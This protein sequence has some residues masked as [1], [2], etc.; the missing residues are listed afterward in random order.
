MK[1]KVLKFGLPLAVFM[2][3][4]VFAFATNSTTKAEDA[5]LASVPGYIF[6]NGKC[7]RVTTC[8]TEEGPLCMYGTTIAHNKINE[9]QCGLQQLY[10][11]SN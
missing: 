1:T 7:E 6:Q 11:W 9:T 4:I 8:S 2:L 10:Q 5:S 3:A